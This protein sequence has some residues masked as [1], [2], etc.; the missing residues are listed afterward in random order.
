MYV[1]CTGRIR[2]FIQRGPS[3]SQKSPITTTE[4]LM[5]TR[6]SRVVYYQPP[7]MISLLHTD[8]IFLL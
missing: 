7:P 6:V 1:D 4:G 2:F 3:E 5:F 8:Q